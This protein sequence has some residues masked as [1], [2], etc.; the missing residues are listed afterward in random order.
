MPGG[1]HS[2]T[3]TRHDLAELPT[4]E[5]P[6]RFRFHEA[7]AHD[8]ALLAD[9]HNHSFSHKWNAAKYREVFRSPH[10]ERELVALAPDGRFAAFTNLWL[11]ELNRSLLFEPV[12]T[13]SDFRR[14]GVGKALM[15]Y[16]LK[17]MREEYG[18]ERAYVCH[19]P[20]SRNPA[21]TALY[22]SVGFQPLHVI[23][24]Y[25]KDLAP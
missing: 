25:G 11:D 10:M 18:I 16:A 4:A 9:V 20:P 2:I 19:E 12:G 22:A 5:L 8:A 15:V 7:A 3:L 14:R 21:S 6:A 1:R 17:R 24:E 23:H 13:H